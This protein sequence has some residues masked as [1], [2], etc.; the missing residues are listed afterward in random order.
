MLDPQLREGNMTAVGV[1]SGV[2]KLQFWEMLLYCFLNLFPVNFEIF[3]SLNLS[4]VSDDDW[5]V[6]VF[7]DQNYF[8][9]LIVLILLGLCGFFLRLEVSLLDVGVV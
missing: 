6:E 2:N 4:L 3:A 1:H 9:V 8:A 5:V 7:L